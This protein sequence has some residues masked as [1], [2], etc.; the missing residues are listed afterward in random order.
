M[1]WSHLGFNSDQSFQPFIQGRIF[2]IVVSDA[3][4]EVFAEGFAT[5]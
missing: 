4:F 2:F 5:N 1:S 3:S